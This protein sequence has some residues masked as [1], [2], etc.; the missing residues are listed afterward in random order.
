MSEI[1]RLISD[2]DHEISTLNDAFCHM[3]DRLAPVMSEQQEKVY[4]SDPELAIVTDVGR[5]LSDLRSRLASLRR[6]IEESSQRL[7]V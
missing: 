2:I 3:L 7:E 5:K 4:V 1:P 6:A